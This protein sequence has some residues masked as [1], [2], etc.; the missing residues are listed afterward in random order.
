MLTTRYCAPTFTMTSPPNPNRTASLASR[1]VSSS[2]FTKKTSPRHAPATPFT[3][4]PRTKRASSSLSSTIRFEGLLISSN[5][6]MTDLSPRYFRFVIR[7]RAGAGASR[8]AR[9]WGF[10]EEPSVTLDTKPWL[11][12]KDKIERFCFEYLTCVCG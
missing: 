1:Y 9:G 12:N 7:I 11:A 10:C 8:K 4:L 2:V 5:L 3:L 6:P